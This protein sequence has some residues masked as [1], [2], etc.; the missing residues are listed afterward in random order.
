MDGKPLLIFP[1]PVRL[2]RDKRPAFFPK[3]IHIPSAKKQGQRL[4]PS[5]NRLNK[6][7]QSG[8]A[9]LKDNP[10]GIIP[11]K[12]LVLE[13]IKPIE[14]F[15]KATRLISGLEWLLETSDIDIS[16]DIDFYDETKKD[17]PLKGRLFLVMSDNQALKELSSL[18]KLYLTK[19]HE[20]FPRGW[21]KWRDLFIHLHDIRTWDVQDRLEDTGILTDWDQREKT[22]SQ[23]VH[24]EM[25][26]WFKNDAAKRD[27]TEKYIRSLIQTE[28]GKIISQAVI[29]DVAYHGLLGELPI[30]AI[31]KFKSDSNTRLLRCDYIMYFRPVGQCAAKINDNQTLP[32]TDSS[33]YS[34]LP[35]REQ[36]VVALLDG[37]PLTN[38]RLL[39][40]RLIIDDPDN[41]AAAYTADERNHGTAMSS[42]ITHGELDRSDAP[43]D[44]K[45]Y[46][47]PILKPNPFNPK[48]IESIP[49]DVLPIDLVHRA[50]HRL[51]ETVGGSPAVAPTVRII[52]LSI[53][54]PSC[55]FHRYISSLAR[56]LDWLSWKYN[57]LFI[58][59]AGNH[60]HGIELNVPR[61]DFSHLSSAALETE[62]LKGI[63][64]DIRNRRLLSPAEAINVLTVAALHSDSSPSTIPPKFT[65]PYQTVNMPSPI[66][67]VGLGYRRAIK[68][69]IL[70][71]GGRQLFQEKLGNT[72][73]K[74]VLEVRDLHIAP[75]QKVASPS[76]TMGTL[77]AVR[78]TRGTSNATALATR[79]A[80][81]I[82]ENLEQLRALPDANLLRS[83]FDAVLL[84]A[85]LVHGASWQ[86]SFSVL[87]DTLKGPMHP[88]VFKEYIA[89]YLGYGSVALEKTLGCTDQ[90]ATLIGCGFLEA[91][92]AHL[93]SM[94]LPPSLSG[95]KVWR[96]LTITLAWL[97]SINPMNQQYRRAYLWFDP[98]AEKSTDN[99]LK[100]KR[101]EAESKAVKRGTVQHEILEGNE[102][103]AF[104]DGKNLKIQVNCKVDAGSFEGAAPYALIVSLEVAPEINLPIYQEIQARI[105]LPVKIKP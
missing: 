92:D 56:L 35:K 102:A 38:H 27:Q 88:L 48:V 85:L 37:L 20:K 96:R 8:Y 19:P 64:Q 93:Y 60:T 70:Y 71:P 13:T 51:F 25:E 80:A 82:Y 57:V 103:V 15:I 50:V 97:T 83:D 79:G 1:H 65:N 36:P 4:N 31:K 84:K 43:L 62:T 10:F 55:L 14:E 52:N 99:I 17:K 73:P 61:A 24:F 12:V 100:I 11:E 34:I 9:E 7:F 46:V 23:I 18:W 101:I 42:L 45:I 47:R 26:L 87:H 30:N 44:R 32:S 33:R 74:A 66:S 39:D 40:G 75:G 81:I 54:D 94:P 104:Q 29:P 95:Q 58:V 49:E 91:D 90:L 105:K 86:Q 69:D 68:P 89:R 21:N 2:E 28:K 63:D 41:W 53:G 67:A 72:H 98:P 59:S 76:T 22:G 5:F 78:Y 77:D 16:P 6:A 3:N